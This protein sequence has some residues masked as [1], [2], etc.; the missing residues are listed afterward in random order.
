MTGSRGQQRG[1]GE[2]HCCVWEKHQFRT[3]LPT[4]AC[5]VLGGPARVIVG[6]G[7]AMAKGRTNLSTPQVHKPPTF[8]CT[9]DSGSNQRGY[10]EGTTSWKVNCAHNP[11]LWRTPS[12]LNAAFPDRSFLVPSPQIEQKC[13]SHCAFLFVSCLC[14]HLQQFALCGHGLHLRHRPGTGHCR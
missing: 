13:A 3:S 11:T 1:W 9:I 4:G 7:P 2:E 14:V 8:A 6:V 10:R 5:L 12:P